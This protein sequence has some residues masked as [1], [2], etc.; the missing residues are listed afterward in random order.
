M[1]PGQR[2]GRVQQSIQAGRRP[3]SLLALVENGFA[4]DEVERASSIKRE[5]RE[6]FLGAGPKRISLIIEYGRKGFKLTD[7]GLCINFDVVFRLFLS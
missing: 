5:R 2:L 6:E 7:V 1:S 4:A 3:L